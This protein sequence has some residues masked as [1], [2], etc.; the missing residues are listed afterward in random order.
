MLTRRFP[1]A[2]VRRLSRDGELM[3]TVEHC[4][5]T[6]A[7]LHAPGGRLRV[8]GSHGDVVWLGN[9]R[10]EPYVH[11]GVGIHLNPHFVITAAG[12]EPRLIDGQ[13]SGMFFDALPEHH[14]EFLSRDRKD[15]VVAEVGAALGAAF[16]ADPDFR[17]HVRAQCLEEDLLKAKG[18]L[19]TVEESLA[20]SVRAYAA[21]VKAV[22]DARQAV[23]EAKWPGDGASDAPDVGEA[24]VIVIMQAPEGVEFDADR[25]REAASQAVERMAPHM[26]A[27]M[28]APALHFIGRAE[29]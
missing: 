17:A 4:G 2:N 12:V 11:Q 23:V 6:V 15:S 10:D 24:F 18:D 13:P 20:D 8:H 27:G 1:A 29:D 16:R 22:R 7:I 21:G 28:P 19:A 3:E 9:Y 5:E 14:G 25:V 26:P